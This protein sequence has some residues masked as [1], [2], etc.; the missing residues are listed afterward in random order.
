MGQ[1]YNQSLR[2]AAHRHLQSA[3]HLFDT[4]RKDVAGYLFGIAAECALKQIMIDSGMRPLAVEQRRD[5]PFFAHFEGL[6]TSLRDSASG[7]HSGKLL[8]F[9]KD[10]A[11]MQH[12][13]VSMRYS[14]G[15]QILEGWVTRWRDNADLIVTEMDT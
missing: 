8:R 14:D 10:T 12:W 2:T 3:K 9:V 4:H 7:R 6:K 5:D 1:E 15:R 13:D 11:F